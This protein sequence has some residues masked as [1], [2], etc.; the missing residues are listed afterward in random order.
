MTPGQF[1]AYCDLA[2]RR[3]RAERAAELTQMVIAGRANERYIQ[4]S[5]KRLIAD[6][7]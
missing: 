7:E 6:D 2:G 1:F 5:L 3:Y 4:Q